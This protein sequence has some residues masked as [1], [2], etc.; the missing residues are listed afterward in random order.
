MGGGSEGHRCNI[1]GT[2]YIQTIICSESF[3]WFLEFCLLRTIHEVCKHTVSN[4]ID[5]YLKLN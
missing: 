4:E 2:K 5:S 3:N 1:G